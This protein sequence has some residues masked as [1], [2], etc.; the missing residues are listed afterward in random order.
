VTQPRCSNCGDKTA[1]TP[2]HRGTAV[3]KS[4]R[5]VEGLCSPCFIAKHPEDAQARVAKQ[6]QREASKAASETKPR[7]SRRR[8]DEMPPSFGDRLE[9][10]SDMLGDNYSERDH[11]DRDEPP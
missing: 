6:K 7:H 1:F 11:W 8:G 2:W 3:I 10:G 5:E 4:P 9:A